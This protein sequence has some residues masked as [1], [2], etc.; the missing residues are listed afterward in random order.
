MAAS[1]THIVIRY[2]A[3][4]NLRFDRSPP[5]HPF[6]PGFL[7]FGPGKPPPDPIPLLVTFLV[8]VTIVAITAWHV[9][10]D[11]CLHYKII[12]RSGH[13]KF[14][15]SVIDHRQH[16]REVVVRR[17]RCR[18]PLERRRFPRIIVGHLLALEDAPEHVEVEKQLRADRDNRRNR[19]QDHERM[20]TVEEAI[21]SKTRIPSWH[22]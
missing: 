11:V 19:D 16:A 5:C 8:L 14:I 2:V 1:T 15:R 18:G 22:T 13:G 9:G 12:R 4:E 21:L 6:P 3:G 10:P 17:R 20:Q 7:P